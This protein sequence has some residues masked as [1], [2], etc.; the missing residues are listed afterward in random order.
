MLSE[1]E[2]RLLIDC[3]ARPQLVSLLF[4]GTRIAAYVENVLLQPQSKTDDSATVNVFAKTP[5]GWR[6][7]R[8][9]VCRAEELAEVEVLA[10]FPETE[11]HYVW[12]EPGE[13]APVVRRRDH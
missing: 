7:E 9:T 6:F 10:P 2:R 3:E 12:P 5:E 4:Q 13:I 1:K 11:R 8:S